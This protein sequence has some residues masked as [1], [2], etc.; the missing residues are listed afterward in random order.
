MCRLQ[1]ILNRTEPKIN[2]ETNS[3]NQF[4]KPIREPESLPKMLQIRAA[5]FNVLNYD[6]AATQGFATD[7]G[8]TSQ[9]EFDR[10]HHI[11]GSAFRWINCR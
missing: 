6:N 7:R 3:R 1:P 9:A 4:K 11:I 2:Q 5:V 8:A 10:Q